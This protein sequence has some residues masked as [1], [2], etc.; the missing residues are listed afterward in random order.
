MK[1]LLIVI[2]L[3]SATTLLP[4][5]AAAGNSPFDFKWSVDA[6]FSTAE[7]WAKACALAIAVSGVV[8]P[9]SPRMAVKPIAVVDWCDETA[10]IL[11]A[12][13]RPAP[14]GNRATRQAHP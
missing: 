14:R 9:G 10:K 8:G 12:R 2:A 4:T 1:S 3:G 6:R 11:F 13:F 5:A 7:Q